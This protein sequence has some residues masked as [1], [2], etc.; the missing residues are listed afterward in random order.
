MDRIGWLQMEGLAH[1]VGKPASSL[2]ALASLK[3]SQLLFKVGG[4][5]STS[6]TGVAVIHL[7]EG[8][9]FDFGVGIPSPG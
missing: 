5:K 7:Y 6:A 4:C 1:P 2:L 9:W 3:H 8:R